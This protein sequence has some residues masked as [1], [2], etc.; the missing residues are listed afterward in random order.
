MVAH[1]S[2]MVQTMVEHGFSMVK[3]IKFKM[4]QTVALTIA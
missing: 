4:S 2:T 1:G 3:H